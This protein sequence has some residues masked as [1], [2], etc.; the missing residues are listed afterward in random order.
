[1][2]AKCTS[3]RSAFA[4][5]CKLKSLAHISQREKITLVNCPLHAVYISKFSQLLNYQ[6]FY[7]RENLLGYSDC[8]IYIFSFRFVTSTYKRR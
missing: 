2:R 7:T 4:Y 8:D 5:N 6:I 3:V 1:M